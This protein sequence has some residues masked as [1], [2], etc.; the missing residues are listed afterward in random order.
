VGS[1]SI[2]GY[3]EDGRRNVA[4]LEAALQ[5][6]DSRL[7]GFGS[8]LDFGCG[9]GRTLQ[10]FPR[11]ERQALHGCDVNHAAV[12]WAR[13]NLGF[14]SFEATSPE[15]PLPYGDASFDLVFALSVFTHL[16][17]AGQDA[18]LA[19]LARVTRPGGTAL[20]SIHGDHARAY[21]WSRMG[22]GAAFGERM[23]REL[24]AAGSGFVFI[25]FDDPAHA[26]GMSASERARY[27]M[28]F[29]DDSYVRGRWSRNWE[30]VELLP[31]AVAGLQDL[32]VL[33]AR[34]A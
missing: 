34:A 3:V 14:V 1:A 11:V 30:V 4:A 21:D 26:P 27:G 10:A 22:V 18:W 16:D 12:E 19:E 25:P 13:E 5:R 6:V 24:A 28:T 31:A 33:R 23:N 15:P 8:V 32:T 20:L 7:E 17:E 29:H 9:C 2:D